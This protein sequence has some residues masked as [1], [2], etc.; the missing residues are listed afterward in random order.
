MNSVIQVNG[1]YYF[2]MVS[3]GIHL[4][5]KFLLFF[6]NQPFYNRK[7]EVTVGPDTY[8]GIRKWP[9]DLAEEIY[10]IP[11]FF[12][13]SI[14]FAVTEIGYLLSNRYQKIQRIMFFNIKIHVNFS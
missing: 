1:S 12:N 5:E 10:V 6:D 7:H 13:L 14:R 4:A 11:V 3:K 9:F 8:Q 2:H